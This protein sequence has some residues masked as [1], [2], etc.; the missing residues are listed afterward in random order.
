MRVLSGIQPTSQLHLGNYFGAVRNWVRL[1]DEHECLFGVVDYHAMTVPFDPATLR[2]QTTELLLDLLGCGLDPER[3][4]LFVQSE[5]PEHTELCWLFAAITPYAW[6]RKMTQFKDKSDLVE[7]QGVSHSAGLLLY[8]V[9]QAADILIYRATGVPVGQ[10]QDQ[11]LE[12]ARDIARTF[13]QRFGDTFPEPEALHTSTPKILSPADP[14]KKMSSSLGP[15]HFV[16]VYEDPASIRKKLASAVTDAG[17]PEPG[18]PPSPGVAGLLTL[19]RAC[20][21]DAQARDFEA[22]FADGQ[23]RYAPLKEAVTE[24]VLAHVAP[25]QRRRAELAADAEGVRRR[26]SEMGAR[27]RD[28]ARGTLAEVRERVGLTPPP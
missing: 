25:L 6:L 19:L 18:A 9:L 27:A 21:E 14:T 26:V 8:P 3:C 17:V 16:G 20:G 10:D 7:S 15:K 13:N 22:R 11:H 4:T 2:R 28:L 5:V 23:R 24:A 12:L 1:Q